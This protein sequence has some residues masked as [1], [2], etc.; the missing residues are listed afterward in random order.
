MTIIE[1]LNF[2]TLGFSFL[3]GLIS[4]SIADDL[5][6]PTV[7]NR[8]LLAAIVS[9]IFC[10]LLLVPGKVLIKK[11]FLI[12][13]SLFSLIYLGNFR[14]LRIVF[15]KLKGEEPCITSISS[16]IGKDPISGFLSKHS[17]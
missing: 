1:I 5:K 7:Y 8:L 17:T 15:I 13:T 6:K 4:F 14:L 3:I 11:E 2:T 12:I 9:F 10:S 16:K